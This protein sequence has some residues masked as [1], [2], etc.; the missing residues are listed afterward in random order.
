MLSKAT[1]AV[2]S[3]IEAKIVDI[4]VD[5]IKG[6]P[7]FTIV[8]LPDS[9]IREARE[10]IRSA[11]ENSG[12]ELPP[13][14]FIINLAPAGFKKQGANCDLPIALTILNSTGQIKSYSSSIACA[15]ELSLDGSVKPVK[16]VISMAICLHKAGIK[17]FIV[18]YE[19]RNEAGVI[20]ELEV[21]AVKNIT[22]AIDALNGKIPRHFAENS[23]NTE[24]FNL[25]FSEVRGQE[26]AKRAIEISAAG[27]HNILLY[28][29]PGSGKTMLAKRIP[30]ILPSLTRE[31][32]IET[33]MIHSAGG[34]LTPGQGLIYSPPFRSPHHTSSDAAVVGGGKFPAAGEISLS[35]NGVLF[36]DEFIEFRNN[37]IQ[38]L[39]QPLEDGEI[40]V[41]RASGTFVFPADFLLVAASNPCQCGFLFDEDVEC[42]C[43]PL[44][45]QSYFQKI[46]GPV[47]DRIDIEVLVSRIPYKNIIDGGSARSSETMKKNIIRAREIQRKR[48]AG[49]KTRFN[50]GMSQ[51]EIIKFCA[52]DSDSE[53]ILETAV[54]KMN[55]SARVFFKILKT[56]RTI[57]DLDSKE[58]LEK[59]HILEA[60]SYKNLHRTYEI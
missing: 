38:C 56:A 17:T 28:G 23:E 55:L 52:L 26:S 47:L 13:K 25:D 8:G 11:I 16:G 53:K 10:R 51:K 46:S 5:I 36:M 34:R 15:G 60:L 57:A 20:E 29:V 48:F 59:K 41:S 33:T 50:S 27:R 19:N 39:R 3:G 22:E 37:V 21:F 49:S 1:S 2:I 30:T 7:N 31:E 9:T 12:F 4:E 32:S 44:K 18:P 45:I 42:T 35:H 58:T 6:L 14:N 43:S 54:N 24:N 40:H